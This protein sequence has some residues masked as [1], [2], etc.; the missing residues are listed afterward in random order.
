MKQHCMVGYLLRRN[1]KE[2][3]PTRRN[4][5]LTRKRLRLANDTN[6]DQAVYHWFVQ[7]GSNGSP[8]FEPVVCAKAT[9]LKKQLNSKDNTFKAST[10]WLIRWKKRHCIECNTISGKI[11]SADSEAADINPLKLWEIL[12]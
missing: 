11:K 1:Q 7:T 4:E 3:P 10:R 9:S 8:I 2:H 12:E 5:G 6:L